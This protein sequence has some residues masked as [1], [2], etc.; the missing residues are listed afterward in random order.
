MSGS[1]EC[2]KKVKRIFFF[3]S[4]IPLIVRVFGSKENVLYMHIKHGDLIG[5]LF[6]LSRRQ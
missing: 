1:F 3:V 4:F 6:Y 5:E 2:Y